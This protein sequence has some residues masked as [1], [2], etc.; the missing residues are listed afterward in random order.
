VVSW[1]VDRTNIWCLE[2]TPPVNNID[3]L[4]GDL[5]WPRITPENEAG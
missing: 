2:N 1:L 3:S 4:S 5:A